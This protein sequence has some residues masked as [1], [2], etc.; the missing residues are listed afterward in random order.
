MI[1]PG[2][3]SFLLFAA[4]MFVVLNGPLWVSVQAARVFATGP[5]APPWLHRGVS[6][7]SRLAGVAMLATWAWDVTGALRPA[8]FMWVVLAIGLF[9]LFGGPLRLITSSGV[10]HRGRQAPAWM[11]HSLGWFVRLVGAGA[12]LSGLVVGVRAATG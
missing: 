3:R 11:E 1:D 7:T 5:E 10:F 6:W 12:L 8:F 9:L 2:V 4:G